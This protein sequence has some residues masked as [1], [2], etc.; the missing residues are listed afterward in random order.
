[1]IYGSWDIN[2]SREIFFVILG[3][4][5]H[6]ASDRC[7]CYF[8]FWTFFR[9]FTT[10]TAQKMKISKKLKK[11]LEISSFYTSVRELMIVCY[12]SWDMVCD[13]CYF[14]FI[15]G[16]FSLSPFPL[17]ARKIKISKKWKK[18]TLRDIILHTCIYQ[19]LWLDDV[20][21]LRYGMRW[22][23]RQMDGHMEKVTHRCGCPT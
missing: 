19:K 7:N 23:D 9:P 2:C 4:F 21:F 5:C 12:C 16:Y 8:S 14:F 10:L 18:K 13:E 11:H 1:M 22:M 17:T 20:W 3:H 6:M 15:L